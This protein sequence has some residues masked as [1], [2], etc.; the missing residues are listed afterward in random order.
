MTTRRGSDV[1]QPE[2]SGWRWLEKKEKIFLPG[3]FFTQCPAAF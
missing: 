1:R 3:Y 2:S